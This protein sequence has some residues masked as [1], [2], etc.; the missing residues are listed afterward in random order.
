[1]KI[2]RLLPLAGVLAL[3]AVA[4]A[5]LTNDDISGEILADGIRKHDDEN[6]HDNHDGSNESGDNGNSG[7]STGGAPHVMD[8]S[9]ACP[10]GFFYAGEPSVQPLI[11][12]QERWE[13]W[14]KGDAS[15]VYSCYAFLKGTKMSVS[16]ASLGCNQLRGQ[17]LS[18]NQFLEEEILLG[19]VFLN[20]LNISQDVKALSSSNATIQ[21]LT[22]GLLLGGSNWT[23]FGADEPIAEGFLAK[24]SLNSSS[25]NSTGNCTQP[26]TDLQCLT[27]SW[28]PN[29]SNGSLM[30]VYQPTSCLA[31]FDNAVCEV[32]VYT[33]TWYVWFYVNW[34]QILF[35][36]TLAALILAS[37]CICQSWLFSPTRRQGGVVQ[38]EMNTATPPPYTEF[39][40]TTPQRRPGAAAA[41]YAR[42]GREI[43]AKV[44][45]YK[46]AQD[47]QPLA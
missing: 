40:Y 37:C 3:S 13:V 33:Q 20:K 5:D 10:D 34:L 12:K 23:W 7:A 8:M 44:I 2:L 41:N 17:L 15:P 14:D 22:S 42:K 24:W 18:V 38:G 21:I 32:R 46:P 30:L 36:F 45:Y 27:I 35:F 9:R 31:T 47:K 29:A 6:H 43:L 19:G 39:Q 25:S 28:V 26:A 1:M 11:E 4:S 16:G